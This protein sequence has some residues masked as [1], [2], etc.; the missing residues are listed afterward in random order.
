[1][2]VLGLDVDQ[3]GRHGDEMLHRRGPA[4]RAVRLADKCRTAMGQRKFQCTIKIDTLFTNHFLHMHFLS[5]WAGQ[6]ND[7]VI[8]INP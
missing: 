3:S 7:P 5:E 4:R 8:S 6:I 2:G 1:M